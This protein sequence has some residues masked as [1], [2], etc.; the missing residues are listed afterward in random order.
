VLSRRLIVIM[1]LACGVG[2]ANIYFSQ[3]LTPLLTRD[4]HVSDSAA[5]LV[6]TL[7]QL[8]YALGVFFLVPLGDRLPRRP[9]IGV[10]FGVVALGLLLSGVSSSAALLALLGVL[11]GAATVVP[12]VLIPMAA[13]LAE[14]R[15]AASVVGAVQGGLLGGI[16]LAR[17]FA[18][19]LGQW[20]SW[21]AP[22][23]IAG[24]LAI[25]F[26]I[27]LPLVLPRL[28]SA[29]RH[30]Y[31]ALIATSL[32]LL[33]EQPDLRRSCQ[34]Q[35]LLFGG[36]SAVWTS[37]AL[38]L[39]S[40][41]YGYGTDVVGVV[42][43]V[44]A[45]SVFTVSVAGRLIDRRGPEPVSLL[46]FVGIALSGVVLLTGLAH[47][48]VGLAGMLLGLLILDV[49]AQWSQVANQGRIFALV[50]GARSRLNSVYMT[51]SFLGGSAGSWVGAH[52][53]LAFGWGAV[54][55]LVVVLG[56]VAFTRHGLRRA[57]PAPAAE[58]VTSVMGTG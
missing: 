17:A 36:F 22:F 18:G 3:A 19:L 28:E 26:A 48:W 13:D 42:A 33:R 6:A 23:L 44:G 50:P 29:T 52:A 56:G 49:A 47:G 37:I 45:A 55:A 32:R 46:C 2:V 35:A 38:Y 54:C 9:L 24:V 12:Q 4:L 16:L 5:T 11:I 40:P 20:L 1:S 51:S 39:T 43:L 30:S 57:T 8:G 25:L 14:G 53:Y 34:Y 31:P 27:V 7:T 10:M 15:S 58:D 21:R 41:A